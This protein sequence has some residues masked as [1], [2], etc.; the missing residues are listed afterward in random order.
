M[1]S[2]YLAAANTVP[3]DAGQAAVDAAAKALIDAIGGEQ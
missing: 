1:K 3:E 2:R